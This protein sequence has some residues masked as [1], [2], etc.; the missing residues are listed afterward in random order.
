MFNND[1]L[2]GSLMKFSRDGSELNDSVGNVVGSSC[3]MNFLLQPH[4]KVA[5]I[6]STEQIFL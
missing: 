6:E 3:I 5:F 4:S 1:P 2:L